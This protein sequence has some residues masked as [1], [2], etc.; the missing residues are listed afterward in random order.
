M[1]DDG[2]DSI[3]DG[4]LLLAGSTPGSDMVF[5]LISC[6]VHS[7]QMIARESYRQVMVQR[8]CAILWLHVD[9]CATIKE[10]PPN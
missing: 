3:D 1:N 6:V 5:V 7:Q 2:D 4:L 10:Q 8:W 9:T